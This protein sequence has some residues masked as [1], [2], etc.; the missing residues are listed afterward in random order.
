MSSVGFL[1]II[2]GFAFLWL[3][4]M[5]PQ[6]RRQVEQQRMIANLEVGDD[7]LTAGGVYGTV[8]ALA[9]DVVTL[10]VASGVELRVAR[11][12][13]AGVT[14]DEPETIEADAVE[15]P[16]EEPDAPGGDDRG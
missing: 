10:E 13:I 12:A 4:V 2:V 14:P 3:V 6:K 1:I 16:P 5:R 15:E 9:G 8:T 11:R 7:V